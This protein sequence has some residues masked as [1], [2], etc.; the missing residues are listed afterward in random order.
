M[1]F[2]D[3]SHGF[4][5]GLKDPGPEVPTFAWFQLDSQPPASIDTGDNGAG[6]G[7][8]GYFSGYLIDSPYAA[9]EPFNMAEFGF[10]RH[11]ARPSNEHRLP[12]PGRDPDRGHRRWW[13]R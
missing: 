10:P 13:R 11:G 6:N 5:Q 4:H 9:F 7:G 2:R 1:K 8:A 12:Q 3:H